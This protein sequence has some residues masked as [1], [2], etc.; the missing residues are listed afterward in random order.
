[1]SEIELI[2]QL[3]VGGRFFQW[4]EVDA[5]EV[6]NNGL[7]E[8]KSV[9]DIDLDED[10]HELQFGENRRAPP[11][12]TGDQLVVTLFPVYRSHND[13]LQDT[14]FLHRRRECYE[15]V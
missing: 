1:M 12:L 2:D 5:V 10:R 4:M 3:L 15:A 11:A 13:R 7:F 8:R 6:L 14:E 9:V